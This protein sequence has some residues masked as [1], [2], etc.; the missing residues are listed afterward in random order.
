MKYLYRRKDIFQ[1]T[2]DIQV[3]LKYYAD[4]FSYSYLKNI[5]LQLHLK[6]FEVS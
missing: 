2:L 1:H 6:Y 5:K 3:Y 4:N